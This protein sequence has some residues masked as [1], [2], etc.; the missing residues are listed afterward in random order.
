MTPHL[1]RAPGLFFFFISR[2]LMQMRGGLQTFDET[3]KNKILFIVKFRFQVIFCNIEKILANHPQFHNNQ[4]CHQQ[5]YV[6]QFL[7]LLKN[8]TS[9]QQC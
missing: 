7:D 9:L 4:V 2:L 5:K 8:P 6:Q 1:N 3:I